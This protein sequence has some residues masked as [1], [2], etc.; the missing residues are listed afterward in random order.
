MRPS[1][2]FRM[3]E[4][5]LSLLAG[6]IFGKT[7]IWKSLAALKAVYYIVSLAN[8]RRTVRAWRGRRANIL[9]VDDADAKPH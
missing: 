5:A 2:Y 7:P 4:A 8:L 9:V 3:K 1:N 6:D